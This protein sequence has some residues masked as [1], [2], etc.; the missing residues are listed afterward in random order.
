MVQKRG[1]FCSKRGIRHR[2]RLAQDR[3]LFLGEVRYMMHINNTIVII[4]NR[5]RCLIGHTA[6][7]FI[8]D[9]F[10]SVIQFTQATRIIYNIVLTVTDLKLN[11]PECNIN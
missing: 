2:Q 3:P 5:L 7:S 11:K 4:R 6:R 9:N 10:S 8:D 1:I